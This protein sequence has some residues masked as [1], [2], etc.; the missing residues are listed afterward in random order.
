MSREVK[1]ATVVKVLGDLGFTK[2]H[3]G[4]HMFFRHKNG[5]VVTVPTRDTLRPITL[6][7][8]SRQVSNGG[9]TTESAFT[10]EVVKAGKSELLRAIAKP[11]TTKP[12]SARLKAKEP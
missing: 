10:R 6:A 11:K 3:R 7:A 12:V 1:T 5:T 8:M 4:R 9:I 2:S